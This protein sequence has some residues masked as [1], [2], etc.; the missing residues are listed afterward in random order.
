V[1]LRVPYPMGFHAEGLAGRIDDQGAGW[2]GKAICSTH[3]GRAIW[4]IDG[5]QRAEEQGGEI[6]ATARSVGAVRG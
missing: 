2:K 6:S 3:A 1:T 5:E 4:H